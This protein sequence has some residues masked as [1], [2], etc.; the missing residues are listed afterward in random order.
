[1]A[2]T[3]KQPLSARTSLTSSSLGTLASA[4]YCTSSAYNCATNEPS[5]V[6]VEVEA[7]TTNT[8]SGNKQ[9]V[10][11]LKES[12]DGT[13]F[14]GGPE[15]G[16]TTTDEGSLLFIGALPI[17]TASTTYRAT[18][19]IANALGYVPDQFK[20]VTKNDLGVALTSGALYTAEVTYTAA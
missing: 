8:P 16:T 17:T 18:F 15:S 14:R 3:T 19:N 20:V 1:M 11:F 6:V 13:N 7:A 2:T 4:T 5:G 9:L 12:L 10:V